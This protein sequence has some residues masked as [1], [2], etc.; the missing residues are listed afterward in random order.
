[1]DCISGNMKKEPCEHT[2]ILIIHQGITALAIIFSVH[3]LKGTSFWNRGSVHHGIIV[4]A[5]IFSIHKVTSSACYFLSNING[6]MS[7]IEKKALR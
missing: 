5:I 3:K 2:I 1:M 4:L 7:C 6:G